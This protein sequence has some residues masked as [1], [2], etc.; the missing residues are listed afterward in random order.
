VHPNA[1]V[2][3]RLG[4]AE[5]A[6]RSHLENVY[7]RLQVPSRTAEV[8]RTFPDWMAQMRS[9][10]WQRR[11]GIARQHGLTQGSGKLREAVPPAKPTNG[12]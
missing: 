1:Q 12:S 9:G 2:A 7:D 8:T 10:R 11:A 4:L 5:G 6:V 3:Q